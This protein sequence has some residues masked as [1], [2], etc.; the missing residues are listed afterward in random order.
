ME[1]DKVKY[2]QGESLVYY[3]GGI[4]YNMDYSINGVK[5]PGSHLKWKLRFLLN[6]LHES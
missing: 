5:Q 6:S 1:Q 3:I 4:S 2:A